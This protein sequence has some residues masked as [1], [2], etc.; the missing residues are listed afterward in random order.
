MRGR[1]RGFPRARGGRGEGWFSRVSARRAGGGG[2][3]GVEGGGGLGEAGHR[4]PPVKG[5]GGGWST[6]ARGAQKCCEGLARA[7]HP[8]AQDPHNLFARFFK[9][10]RKK[11]PRAEGGLGEAS[12][13]EAQKT[14]L[15]PAPFCA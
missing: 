4:A 1:A 11:P 12:P 9:K 14:T 5:W 6:S 7:G 3:E 2:L 13:R 15:A 10:K 8:R